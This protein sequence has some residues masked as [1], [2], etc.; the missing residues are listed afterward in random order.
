M[1]ETTYQGRS[2]ALPVC[3]HR[4]L[5]GFTWLRILW[6]AGGYTG[7]L[8]AGWIKGLRPKLAV[9]VVN[10]SG[11]TASGIATVPAITYGYVSTANF[12]GPLTAGNVLTFYVAV[13][14]SGVTA[15]SGSSLAK[16]CLLITKLP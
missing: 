5:G 13:N 16:T 9:T 4:V 11:P 8:F 6:V 10:R 2:V 3:R 7:K 14:V 15:S 1:G 12:T